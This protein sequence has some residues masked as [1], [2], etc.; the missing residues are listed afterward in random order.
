MIKASMKPVIDVKDICKHFGLGVTDFAF[1]LVA[2]NKSYQ[3]F[4]CSA[5]AEDALDD[6]LTW[7]QRHGDAF[8]CNRIA[9]DYALIKLLRAQGFDDEILIYV[10]W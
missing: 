1:S 6:E 10:H 3:V 7:T 8:H 4:D 2:E 9:N 5:K